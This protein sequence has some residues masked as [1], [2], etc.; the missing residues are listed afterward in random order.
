MTDPVHCWCREMKA[1]DHV[2][3]CADRDHHLTADPLCHHHMRVPRVDRD[4]VEHVDEMQPGTVGQRVAIE[5]TLQTRRDR[6][7]R[8]LGRVALPPKPTEAPELLTDDEH[9]AVELA[10]ELWNLLCQITG[11]GPNRGPDLDEFRHSIHQVQH[12]VMKQAAARAYPDR[13]HLLGQL[14]DSSV[15]EQMGEYLR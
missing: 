10:G 1:D 9:Q 3:P 15:R 8:I 4:I 2:V 13:Y 7:D 5:Q 11:D 14:A 6:G 12:G